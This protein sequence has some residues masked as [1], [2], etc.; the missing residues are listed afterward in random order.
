VALTRELT[1]R[2]KVSLTTNWKVT[3]ATVKKQPEPAKKIT[4]EEKAALDLATIYVFFKE[5]KRQPDFDRSRPSEYE[6][7]IKLQYLRH[8]KAKFPEL[9]KID[10]NNLLDASP[11]KLPSARTK[12]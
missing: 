12:L 8:H 9:Q 2:E 11:V 5:Q 6:L 4:P 1:M 7:S 10:K 3:H